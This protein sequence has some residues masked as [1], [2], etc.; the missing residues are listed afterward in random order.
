MICSR[1]EPIRSKIVFRSVFLGCARSPSFL[2]VLAGNL[3]PAVYQVYTSTWHEYLAQTLPGSVKTVWCSHE[4]RI[5]SY[6]PDRVEPTLS[7]TGGEQTQR[8]VWLWKCPL[9]CP[10]LFQHLHICHMRRIAYHFKRNG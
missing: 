1:R 3:A 7:E 2:R 9:K 10:L 8:K 5:G 6:I 4:Y